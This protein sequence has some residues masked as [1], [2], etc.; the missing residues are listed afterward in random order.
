M[1]A[2]LARTALVLLILSLAG[3]ARADQPADPVAR[4]NDGILALMRAAESGTPAAAR[5]GDF[6]P[7][8]RGSFDL[9]TS[10]RVAVPGYDRALEAE[11]RALLDAFVRRNAAQ[12]VS[13]F[14]GYSGETIEIAG[15]RSGPRNTTLVET[16]LLRPRGS[17]VVLTY[18]VR[19]MGDGWGIVDV[20][21]NGSVSQL[22]V[23]RSDFAATLRSGG[24][25][26]LIR[27]FDAYADGVTG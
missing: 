2:S 5:L 4:L 22:A 9:E 23:Q 25:P 3:T 16:R 20:L 1:I 15:E 24:I 11:R 21:L 6:E 26:A 18:V 19:R 27:E 10:L 7:V 12:Y 13:R 17:P 8:V 14:D